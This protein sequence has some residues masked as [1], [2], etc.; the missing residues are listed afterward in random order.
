MPISFPLLPECEGLRR[1]RAEELASFEEDAGV[2]EGQAAI[3]EVEQAR[4]V[5]RKVLRLGEVQ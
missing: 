5:V 1:R 2:V 3:F 4:D